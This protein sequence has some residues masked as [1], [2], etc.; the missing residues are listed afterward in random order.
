MNEPLHASS[1]AYEHNGRS[2]S[3]ETFYAVACDPDRSVA[4]EACAGAGKTWMLVSRILRALLNGSEPHEILAITFTKKAAGEMRQRL[5]EWLG[6]FSRQ[7]L[8]VLKKELAARGVADPSDAECAR[9][10]G[11]FLHMLGAGRPVQIR[12]FHSWFAALL[13]TAPIAVLQSRGLPVH[14]ELLQDD[15]EA[16]RQVWPLFLRRVI[17]EEGLHA[18]YM[19]SV[20]RH[21]RSQ[22][23]KALES[24]LAKR[25]EFELADAGGAVDAS[26]PPFQ[27]QWPE[28]SA[29]DHP[30]QALAG[31][32][33][34]A[35]WLGWAAAMGAET[36]KTPQKAAAAVVAAFFDTED[37]ESRLDALRRALFV[38]KE[39]RLTRNLEK[40]AAAQEAERELQQLCLA[41]QQH[42]AWLHQQRMAR[43]TR[44]LAAAFAALKRDRGWVDMN[45]VERTAL[46]MLSDPVLSGWVQERLD[47]RVRHLLIDEFQDT[48]P[49]Q[50]QALHAWL[51]GYVG[52]GGGARPPSVFIVGDPKQSIYRFR[53]AE[54]QVFR[55]AQA[56]VQQGLGGDLL[57]CDHTRRNAINV[58]AA[59]N[60]V[61]G[62]A[63]GQG[64]YAGFRNHTTESH[65]AGVLV[66]L[67]PVFNADD[68]DSAV[69]Q[70]LP[71]PM[72]WR[73][74]LE[75]PRHEAEET[76]R[77]RECQQAARWVAE[78]MAAGTPP[79]EIMVLARK[80]DR[81]AAMQD[82]LRDLHIP[83]VQPENSELCEAP[84]VQDVVALL[85]ALLSPGHDLSMAR[86]LRSPLFGLED[87]LLVRIAA[88]RRQAAQSA[89]ATHDFR[90]PSWFD[91]LSKDELLDEEIPRLSADLNLYRGWVEQWPPHDA[92]HAI[93]QHRDVLARY[94]AAAP[95]PLRP[96]ML[97]NLRALLSAALQQDGGRYLTPYAFVRALKRPGHRA[98][99]RVDAQAVRLLTI[100][101]AKGLEADAVLLLDTDSRGQKAETMGVLVDWPGES[102][103][104]RRFIFLASES[105]P[106]PSAMDTL[107]AE[108]A[109]RLR[110]ELNTLYVAMTRA[111]H[112]L[113]LSCVRLTQSAA[114]SWWNRVAPLA[115][116]AD[117]PGPATSA[118]VEIAPDTAQLPELPG[119]GAV[120]VLPDV[121][122]AVG[123]AVVPNPLSNQEAEASPAKT[124]TASSLVSRQGEAMH[125]LLEQAGFSVKA[126]ASQ[127]L[128]WTPERLLQLARDFELPA[129]QAERAAAM[130]GHILEGEG[131]WAWD[132][133]RIDLAMDEAPIV[134]LG[135]TLRIDRLV[136]CRAE[137]G[138]APDWW[139][140]DYKSA[141]DPE[142]QPELVAQLRRYRMAVL[143]QV[144]KG[145]VRA[146]F[147]TG[148]GR[149]VEVDPS[150]EN[151]NAGSGPP[152]QPLPSPTPV[153]PA[154]APIPAEGPAQGSLFD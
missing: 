144:H 7:P 145:A 61:M 104:P 85:D 123:V 18:D 14:Y 1:A 105:S 97:A 78:R 152:A 15:A 109:E 75:Q 72:A 87:R 17:A 83:C 9:L 147:L 84:E 139:V 120:P 32:A 76:L 20:A 126:A 95:A 36:N 113:A 151:A 98:P 54:P 143:A 63:Q 112:C 40:F 77:M 65:D 81:L 146:A 121:R 55:A 68:G 138:H 51:A 73:D 26:V 50:W 64:E 66:R 31:E 29:M 8:Q 132:R 12:T 137:P 58:I 103:E 69:A 42:E 48:N 80:R 94:A 4:V 24:A 57:A 90:L 128:D 115:S 135:Q 43:L 10:Q 67:P 119:W 118:E 107:A 134:H 127:R 100:H 79:R 59:V 148:D 92:L 5:Q 101:G 96:G 91:L 44:A 129:D 102:P 39:D 37:L 34:R 154:P 11:L 13:G 25:V 88:A 6:D 86:A 114:G 22:T 82:A 41:R 89:T 131:A 122:P 111:R 74:S 35:R 62:T 33:C 149:M 99:G 60:A 56:F 45:D 150:H 116:D 124:R 23:R 106:P 19:Q 2:V 130:A 117:C 136:R 21:G 93:Y 28:L 30:A 3:R 108:Q 47:A 70:P 125:Q 49:L 52:S 38:A 140:L 153:P 142:R 53:R 133:S 46:V 110:E 71:D 16:V 27:A 141:A